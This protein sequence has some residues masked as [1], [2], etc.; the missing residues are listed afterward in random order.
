MT[1]RWGLGMGDR[2]PS[3]A[4]AAADPP[5]PGTGFPQNPICGINNLWHQ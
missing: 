1:A 3:N 2:D 5:P 4:G